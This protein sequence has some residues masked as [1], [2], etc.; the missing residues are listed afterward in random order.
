ML[1][2][3][4]AK[5]LE[6]DGDEVRFLGCFN[7]EPH[8]EWRMRQFDW[9]ECLVH[10]AYFSDLISE[11]ST[12][13][14]APALRKLASKEE[15]LNHLLSMSQS[16]KEELELSSESLSGWADVAY[17]LQSSAVDYEPSGKVRTM[18]VFYCRPLAILSINKQQ[19]LDDHLRQW[20][21]FVEGP[22]YHEVDGSHYTM[23]APEHVSSF[24][25][26]LKRTMQARSV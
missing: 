2:F 4:V 8:I 3:E 10:L 15:A 11:E 14:V 18:D 1:A 13:A 7:L 6:A 21:E 9:V 17:S 22:A 19:W 23:L 26:R 12:N 16:R 25:K 20:D 24:Q 5:R